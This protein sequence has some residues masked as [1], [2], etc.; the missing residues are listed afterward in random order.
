MKLLDTLGDSKSEVRHASI[1]FFKAINKLIKQRDPTERKNFYEAIY[2]RTMEGLRSSDQNLMHGSL[3][4]I[5]FL[6]TESDD[7]LRDKHEEMFKYIIALSEKKSDLIKPQ[8]IEMFPIMAE[9]GPSSFIKYSDSVIAYL[10][11]IAK[12]KSS[13]KG[14]A[15]K[16]LG[17][18][19]VIVKKNKFKASYVEEIVRA[20]GSEIG[21]AK[22]TFF[23]EA[24]DSLANLCKVQGE[25]LDRITDIIDLINV[26]FRD[27]L[28]Q[29]LIITLNEL[30]KINGYKYRKP[31][32]IKL[33]NVISLVLSGKQFSFSRNL[34]SFRKFS[35]ESRE[36]SAREFSMESGSL[37]LNTSE[38]KYTLGEINSMEKE[39][40]RKLMNREVDSKIK[41]IIESENKD[42]M[43]K[44]ALATLSNF[45]FSDF[46]ES[47]THF[48]DEVVL[49]YLDN[50]NDE[51][52]EAAVK[53]CSNLTISRDGN[54]IGSVLEKILKKLLKRFLIVA[55]TDPNHSIRCNMLKHMS[56]QF[57]C[58]LSSKENL[59]MLFNC[60]NDSSFE[61]RDKTLRILGRLAD[62]N[63]A[64][65]YPYLRNLL[66]SLMSTIEY[67]GDPQEK[68]EAIKIL[69]TF[70]KKCKRVVKDHVDSLLKSLLNKMHEKDFNYSL[71]PDIIEAI[72][73]LSAI[74][75]KSVVPY[76]N[77]LIPLILD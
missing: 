45:D 3:L 43:I 9:C 26:V 68:E 77:D 22:S 52:R 46:A 15:L 32:Q 20:A 54:R 72:G 31:I 17:K 47:L 11:E 23:N 74:D 64:I 69:H 65:M 44:L 75:G 33:L 57:D 6:L 13:L 25:E 29:N 12:S 70:V 14:C 5:S 21:A 41:S 36:K 50:S 66:V 71:L 67:K 34:A 35:D 2:L 63:K 30:S 18:L 62:S 1:D 55:T 28:S 24:L 51:I 58:Y 60:M 49:N 39:T 59:L 37:L 56:S 76:L 27:G 8:C 38:A 53:T 48:F 7:L 16:A 42:L 4:V 40:M 73:Q 61:I 10:L 19:S